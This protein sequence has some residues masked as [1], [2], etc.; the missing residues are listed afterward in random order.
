MEKAGL[1]EPLNITLGDDIQKDYTHLESAA[2]LMGALSELRSSFYGEEAH[3]QKMIWLER[4]KE[5][6]DKRSANFVLEF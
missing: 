4:G 6:L 5:M 3:A 1:L 2:I